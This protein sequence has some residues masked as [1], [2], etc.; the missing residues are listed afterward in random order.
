M[1]GVSDRGKPADDF[2][3]LATR[4]SKPGQELVEQFTTA[5]CTE[6][7]SSE[8]IRA[9]HDFV[10][11]IDIPDDR[12]QSLLSLLENIDE[13]QAD[14]TQPT[15]LRVGL[16]ATITVAASIIIELSE[17]L[18]SQSVLERYSVRLYQAERDL[19]HEMP[20]LMG[21]IGGDKSGRVR[22]I[23]RMLDMFSAAR[24]YNLL[25]E[26]TLK[27]LAKSLEEKK[28]EMKWKATGDWLIRVNRL[29]KKNIV[30]IADAIRAIPDKKS[31]KHPR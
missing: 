16:A 22:R 6:S 3:D 20:E 19:T 28:V 21:K 25:D 9:L 17:L 1:N 12:R 15:A 8:Q 2:S 31:P 13:L 4:V 14:D 10:G 27:A 7:G 29:T 23:R 26:P 18:T 5:L 24:E 11:S 30:I